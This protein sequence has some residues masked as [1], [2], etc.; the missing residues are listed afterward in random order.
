MEFV[1]D[2]WFNSH[3]AAPPDATP[4]L[5]D[6]CLTQVA[7]GG[8]WFTVSGAPIGSLVARGPLDMDTR[9]TRYGFR[10]A[11]DPATSAK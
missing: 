1:Q 3:A 6:G 7:R 4:R 2:C 11:R 5:R 10:V 8:S 9:G